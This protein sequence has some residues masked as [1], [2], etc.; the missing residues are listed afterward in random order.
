MMMLVS[1]YDDTFYINDI[2]IKKNI[3]LVSPL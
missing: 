2:D 3:E 1:D